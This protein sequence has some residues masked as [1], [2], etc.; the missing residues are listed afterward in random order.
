MNKD[1][2]DITCLST[3]EKVRLH[4]LYMA[5]IRFIVEKHGG[6]METDRTTCLASIRIPKGHTAACFHELKQLNLIKADSGPGE[7]SPGL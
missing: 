3:T 7:L 1:F 6:T 5:C 4:I 2:W